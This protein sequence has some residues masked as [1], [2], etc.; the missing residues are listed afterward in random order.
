MK[1]VDLPVKGKIV[2][3]RV[4]FNVPMDA[5]GNILDDTRIRASLPTIQYLLDQDASVILMSHLGRPK[6]KKDPKLSLAP[7]A[8]RLSQ[9]LGQK[10]EMSELKT[11]G[12]LLLE[13]LRFDPAEEAPESNPSFAANLAKLG[14]FF[15]NDAFA[16]AHRVHSSTITIAEHFVGKSAPGFLMQKE[17][18]FLGKY[19]EEP[20]RP[21][22]AIIGGA[23]VSSKLG[24]LKSL[25]EKVDALFIGG[26]MAYTFLKV[27]GKE[28]G[29]SLVE[30]ELLQT[31]KEFLELAE[32]KKIPVF[33]PKDFI[34][35]DA[36]SNDATR[37]IVLSDAGIPPGFQGLDIGPIT[38]TEWANTFSNA[39]MIFWNGP[40]G[41]FEFSQF[42]EGTHCIA[43]ALAD[44]DAITIVGGG[45]SIAAINQLKIAEQFTHISTG[46]GACIE[47]IQHGSLPGIDA[48]K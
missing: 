2:L 42:A 36:F 28:I 30:N 24:V 48:L 6:G 25:L 21:F 3:V 29:D 34:A 18:D 16:T 33:L 45:D 7:C 39:Q 12:V 8:E 15:V 5:K 13:N 26:G 23:K 41:V 32:K 1:L 31:A 17:I 20:P 9:L 19:F 10:V 27:Q 4:D 40:L 38:R 35:A 43:T 46:G 37:K 11:G 22:Y 44:L 14:D 47:Y